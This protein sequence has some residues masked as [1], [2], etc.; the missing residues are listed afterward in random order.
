M[1]MILKYTGVFCIKSLSTYLH[2][3]YKA[4]QNPSTLSTFYDPIEVFLTIQP[5]IIS[6]AQ[7]R[8]C[9]CLL[10]MHL[11]LHRQLTYSRTNSLFTFH[12]TFLFN[13]T[14]SLLRKE[15]NTI[16]FTFLKRSLWS[17]LCEEW[18]KKGKKLGMER[19]EGLYHISETLIAWL[20]RPVGMEL[21][22]ILGDALKPHSLWCLDK[23][24]LFKFS[25]LVDCGCRQ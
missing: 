5:R 1:Q 10:D 12:K 2:T 15:V 3:F 9:I 21:H 18:I 11:H 23:K 4:T 6:S 25:P 16:Q 24:E 20:L 7:N 8:F 19:R 17:L 14:Y 13:L 22:V